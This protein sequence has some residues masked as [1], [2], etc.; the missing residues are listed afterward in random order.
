MS[1]RISRS[2]SSTSVIDLVT[3]FSDST[4]MFALFAR[5]CKL[6]PSG[7]ARLY[8]QHRPCLQ[9][10]AVG[11]LTE[12][13]S[14]E[15]VD[16][17]NEATLE[18]FKRAIALRQEIERFKAQLQDSQKPPREGRL[19]L[20]RLKMSYHRFLQEMCTTEYRKHARPL[21]PEPSKLV[22][23]LHRLGANIGSQFIR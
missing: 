5:S 7:P 22:K 13:Y 3:F 11:A 6:T 14:N 20:T 16:R 2:R 12:F 19:A 18:N 17:L 10:S 9:N 8:P 23:V 15:G 21:P 4:K 1:L